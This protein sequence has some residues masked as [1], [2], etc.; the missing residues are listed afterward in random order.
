[1]VILVQAENYQVGCLPRLPFWYNPGMENQI[2]KYRKATGLT[3]GQLAELCNTS[4]PQIQRLESGERKLTR[5][6]A[7]RIAPHLGVEAANLLFD[8]NELVRAESALTPLDPGTAP[9]H[10]PIIGEVAAGVFRDSVELD[11]G[12]WTY[13][14]F[15]PDSRYPCVDRFCLRVRGPSM[16]KIYPEGSIVLCVGM[17]AADLQPEEGAV[18]VVDRVI[19]GEYE[20]TLKELRISDGKKYLWPCSTDPA[21]QQP[22]EYNEE[23]G[24]E[25]ILRALVIGAYVMR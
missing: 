10:L 22:V 13:V 7:R 1:M 25:A 2:K 9:Q 21:H 19:H 17:I 18:Y 8:G 24:E 23:N 14:F 12:D 11:Q 16:N 3:Q 20:S 15:P 5:E 4:P 6:W